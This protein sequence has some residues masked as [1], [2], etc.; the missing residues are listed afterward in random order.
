MVESYLNACF[1]KIHRLKDLFLQNDLCRLLGWTIFFEGVH[2]LVIWPLL[3]H[4]NYTVPFLCQWDCQ[5]YKS[6]VLD[7][8][9]REAYYVNGMANFAFFPLVPLLAK[10]LFLLSNLSAELSLIFVSEFMYFWCIF[11]FILFSRSFFENISPNIAAAT[12]VFM[13]LSV[14][15]LAGYTESTFFLLTMLVFLTFSQKKYMTCGF[16]G[17]LL[18]MTRSI[19]VFIVPALALSKFFSFFKLPFREKVDFVSCMM[20]IPLGLFLYMFYLWYHT[21]DALAFFHVQIGWRGNPDHW[22][23]FFDFWKNMGAPYYSFRFAG[24]VISFVSFFFIV[25][26]FFKK[27]YD[28]AWFL[29]FCTFV[30]LMSGIYSMLRFLFWNP[31]FLLVICYFLNKYRFLLCVVLPLL[32][33]MMMH[34]YFYFLY[35]GNL[36]TV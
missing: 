30:P 35:G 34:A 20:L 23:P 8:Y 32:A 17:T 27:K 11:V 33:A 10:L 13:P 1:S 25:F 14:H 28:L 4:V 18:S 5:W 15:A 3:Q 26:L 29:L 7:G 19:G 12:F 22:N 6:I 24:V 36:W 16:L 21:G 2:L 9:H 31:A